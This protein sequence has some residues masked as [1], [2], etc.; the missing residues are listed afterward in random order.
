MNILYSGMTPLHW[1]VHKGHVAIVKYLVDHGAD[2][3]IKGR[4]GE[5][6]VYQS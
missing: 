5:Y 1:S 4:N 3:N 6:R 2:V